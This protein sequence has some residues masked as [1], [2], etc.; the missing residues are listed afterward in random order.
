[1][2]DIIFDIEKTNSNRQIPNPASFNNKAAKTMEPITGASTWAL[3]SH[4][5][6]K[7]IGNLTKNPIILKNM[8]IWVCPDKHSLVKFERIK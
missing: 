6:T 8:I 4:K 7:N 2:R 3:G 1:M 5:W